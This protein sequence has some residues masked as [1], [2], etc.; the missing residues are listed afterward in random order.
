MFN[1]I[2]QP[3]SILIN[4]DKKGFTLH[5]G[6]TISPYDFCEDFIL[7]AR[8]VFNKKVRMAEDAGEEKSIILKI[9]NSIQNDEG[10][11]LKCENRRV[12]INAKTEAGLF[13]GLQTLKQLLLQSEGKIP[14]VE[15]TDEPRFSYRGYMLDCGATSFWET[16]IGEADFGRAGSLCHGWSAMP[17]Y[18][19]N[20]LK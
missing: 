17:L 14:Y 2:P 15:I 6:T 5:A 1:I 11:T 20:I 8:N 3:V 9:D 4:R 10:Y 7:F 18:Y 16:I 13:Y 19:Y 12:L